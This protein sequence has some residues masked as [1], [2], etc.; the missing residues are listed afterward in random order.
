MPIPFNNTLRAIQSDG[1]AGERVLWAGLAVLAVVWALWMGLASV[2]IREISQSA[3]LE[4]RLAPHRVAATVAGRATSSGLV[5]DRRVA[6][7]EVLVVLDAVD[8]DLKRAEE[9]GRGAAVARRIE[10][11]REEIAAR[12]LARDRETETAGAAVEAAGHRRRE[13]EIALEAAREAERRV[14]RLN[15][16]GSASA[17]DA[18]RTRSEVLRLAALFDGTAAEIRRIE[19]AALARSAEQTAQLAALGQTLAALEGD[20]AASRT[21][22]A[23][24]DAEIAARTLRAPVDG[25]L[26]DVKPLRPGDYVAEGETLATIVPEGDLLAVATFRPAQAVGRIRP[27]QTAGLRLDTYPWARFGAVPA[28][29]LRVGTEVRDDRVRVEFA[30]DPDA[31][32]AIVVQHGMTGVIDVSVDSLTPAA[33]VLRSAGVTLAAPRAGGGG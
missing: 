11:L 25:R 32:P 21:V 24:F 18:A 33:L 17:V 23:R 5:I 4:A 10:A 20:L 26:G 8:L 22:V 12:V 1:S 6:A 19:T 30:I 9:L 16:V 27:G 31:T 15:A 28:T 3:R 14:G 7:G 13:A 2:T 29:V